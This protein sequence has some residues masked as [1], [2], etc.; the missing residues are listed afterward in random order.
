MCICY[1][2]GLLE[3]LWEVKYFKLRYSGKYMENIYK[4]WLLLELEVE[5]VY[6]T[7]QEEMKERWGGETNTKIWGTTNKGITPI[8]DSE[9]FPISQD[10]GPGS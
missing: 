7:N 4:C 5:I 2:I 10:P 9:I 1:S 6:K 3:G 8:L